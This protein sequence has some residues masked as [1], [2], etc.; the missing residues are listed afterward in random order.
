MKR[1]KTI[2]QPLDR[3]NEK[4][5]QMMYDVRTHP[6]VASRLS[7][8]PPQ[9]YEQHV[10]Y[11]RTTANKVFFLIAAD[12]SLCGY[13]QITIRPNEMELGWAL[14]PAWWGKSIGSAAVK[15]L[16][17]HVKRTY[18]TRIDQ[19]CLV[20]KKDNL[21]AIHIYQKNGFAIHR[22]DDAK[23]EHFMQYSLQILR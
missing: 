10:Q 16:V 21:P 14:H 7:G 20:V 4:H 6:E 13:C 15:L 11:L 8:P 12:R 22:S 1:P 9:N 17:E 2:L 5:L 19:I 18:P 3:S 23:N